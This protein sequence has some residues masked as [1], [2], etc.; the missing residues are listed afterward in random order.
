MVLGGE[1]AGSSEYFIDRLTD[2]LR[3][4][5]QSGQV[6]DEGWIAAILQAAALT[7]RYVAEHDTTVG[8]RISYRV[9]R[10]GQ[11]EQGGNL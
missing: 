2:E 8:G 1:G 11:T 3:L 5:V 4:Q 9:L 7:V 6:D 10:R